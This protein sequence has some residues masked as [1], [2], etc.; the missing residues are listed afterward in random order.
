MPCPNLILGFET[1]CDETA[2]AVVRNGNEVLS[3]VVFSQ[4]EVHAPFAGVVPELASRAHLE[5]IVPV[6][7]QALDRAHCQLNQIDAL[8]VGNRPGLI[9][10]LLV[11]VSAAK[12]LAWTLNRPLIGVDHI[13]AH[14]WA[15]CL[16]NQPLDFPALGLV[17]SGGHTTLMSLTDPLTTNILGQ[18]RDDAIGEAF[19]KAATM[20][21]LPYPG[22]P[23]LEKAAKN[24]HDQAVK[25]PIAR[26]SP[27][28]L[29]FSFSGLKTAL[30]YEVRGQPPWP[31][32]KREEPDPACCPDRAASFQKAAVD[33]V[34][35]KVDRALTQWHQLTDMTGPRS[36]LVGGGVSA[37]QT[38]REGLKSLAQKHSIA[39]RL[40]N[41]EYC[42]DNAAMIA[43]LADVYLKAGRID[44]L[45]LSAS[46]Q[47]QQAQPLKETREPS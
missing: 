25:F 18:T 32:D 31:K 38:L 19:D 17:V 3:S 7:E 24:G 16:E 8:A 13:L 44:D 14:L 6:L 39:L 26:L 9:G 27:T 12:T 46:A 42:V 28:S 2:I 41:S 47:R 35:L 23:S 10:S 45:S 30:L 37:N 15:P 34:L 20:L 22:G 11:G 5:R 43:G 40:A 29:D 36:L 21:G 1:S 4:H 33:A